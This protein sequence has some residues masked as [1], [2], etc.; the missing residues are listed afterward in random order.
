MLSMIERVEVVIAIATVMQQVTKYMSRITLVSN[1][2]RGKRWSR[3]P[4][5]IQILC[6]RFVYKVCIQDLYT[7]FL[8]IQDVY[9]RIIV[10]KILFTRR[11]KLYTR[12]TL[13]CCSKEEE[14]FRDAKD[15]IM[16]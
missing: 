2:G 8:C 10:Y 16:S 6:T 5:C 13:E 4:T 3:P 1:N 9:T 14:G 7:R 11:K 12:K 15:K